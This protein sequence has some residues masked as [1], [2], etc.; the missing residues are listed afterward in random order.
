VELAEAGAVMK[1]SDIIKTKGSVVKTVEPETSARELSVRLHAEQIGAMVVSRDGHSIDGI[2]T[3]REIAYGLAAYGSEL[4]TLP[5]SRLMAKAVT[6]CSPDDTITHVMK[7]M[8]QRRVRH[9]LVKDG[10]RLVGIVSIGDILKHR[11]DE[12]ELEANVMRDYAVA[13]RR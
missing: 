12:L 7:V 9:V 1:V 5:V 2:V 11:V 4:P 3:E 10:D 6:V 8:T 13:A